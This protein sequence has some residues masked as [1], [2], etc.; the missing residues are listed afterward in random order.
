M[1]IDA[2]DV[3]AENDKFL[4]A[5]RWAMENVTLG[6][7]AVDVLRAAAYLDL[8]EPDDITMLR[9]GV[10]L[11]NAAGAAGAD[12][13]SGYYQQAASQVRDII[14][15]GFLLDLFSRESREINRWRVTDDKS[16]RK[17]FSASELRRRLNA[18]DGLTDDKRNQAYQLFTAHGTH[19]MPNAI[20][21]T[22]PDN[23]TQIGPFPDRARVVALSFDIG[24]Y[25]AAAAIY[26]A[27]WL[28]TRKLPM[29]EKTQAFRKARAELSDFLVYFSKRTTSSAE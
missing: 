15:V 28:E 8:N 2:H 14:E 19:V 23:N 22:S 18:L 6:N 4:R 17:N 12:A 16:R 11:I 25:L 24:R 21:L 10:R 27:T 7:R 26:L 13:L 3:I 1:L 5:S 9:L 29:D 20:A